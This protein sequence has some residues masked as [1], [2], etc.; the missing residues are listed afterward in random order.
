MLSDRYTTSNAVHQAC[1]LP[2]EQRE[3]FLRWLADF[4]YGKLGLPEPD[5]VLWMERCRLG[6]RR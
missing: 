5:L 4:E 3:D 1:K 6:G 2:P